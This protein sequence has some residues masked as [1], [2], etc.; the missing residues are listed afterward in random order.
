MEKKGLGI[1]AIIV[2]GLLVYG[3]LAYV[4]YLMYKQDAEEVIITEEAKQIN[5]LDSLAK[6]F[7]LNIDSLRN[8]S[9]FMA[10][11]ENQIMDTEVFD[12][13]IMYSDN[14]VENEIKRK[15]PEL[16]DS[17]LVVSDSL[18]RVVAI[19]ELKEEKLLEFVENNQEKYELY[20][21]K[22][23]LEDELKNLET[24]IDT[25]KTKSNEI[26]NDNQ[27]KTR[28]IAELKAANKHLQVEASKLSNKDLKL[29][30]KKYEA[31]KATNAAQV[32]LNLPE[33]D[34]VLILKKM[35]NRKAGK[36]LS[37]LPPSK[38]ASV[39]LKILESN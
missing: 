25:I 24:K 15:H 29:L 8:D 34:I 39:S 28:E 22:E 2:I 19:A 16:K 6:K 30:V 21:E 26:I 9:L 32:M 33:D 38:A 17:A 7:K 10:S 1:P 14:Y 20:F 11:I 37:A 27:S 12:K 31:M 18:R 36:I 13:Y 5:M 23:H 35:N 3:S 4:F